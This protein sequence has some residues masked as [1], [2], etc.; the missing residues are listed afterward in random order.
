[1][2]YCNKCKERLPE[3]V[4]LDNTSESCEGNYYSTKCIR[5]VG[6]EGVEDYEPL[7][8]TIERLLDKIQELE[9]EIEILNS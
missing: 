3:D 6:I 4:F 9:Y 8:K 7:N 2:G 5:A 1:M